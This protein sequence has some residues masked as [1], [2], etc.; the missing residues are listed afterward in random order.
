MFLLSQYK[1]LY[2]IDKALSI[3]NLISLRHKTNVSENPRLIQELQSGSRSD[4][5]F[6]RSRTKNFEASKAYRASWG[7]GMENSTDHVISMQPRSIN[8]QQP[9]TAGGPSGRYITR[10][11]S[12]YFS[13]SNAE[14]L[15]Y[16]LSA[17]F[18]YIL[19]EVAK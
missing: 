2:C 9:Q 7:D 17:S 13:I 4:F 5:L 16:Q 10:F 15:R 1:K 19:G 6:L 12:S 14:I 18:R 8:Q 11:A 3:Q